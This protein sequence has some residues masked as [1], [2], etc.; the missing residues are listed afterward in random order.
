MYWIIFA[1]F[2]AGETFADV[3]L[4]WLVKPFIYFFFLFFL[5]QEST[6]GGS[7]VDLA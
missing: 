4:S 2:T 7:N 1:F 6:P 3:L 5:Y